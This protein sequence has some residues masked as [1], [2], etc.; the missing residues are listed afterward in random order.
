MNVLANISND[1]ERASSLSPAPDQVARVFLGI[2]DGDRLHFEIRTFDDQKQRKDK[3]LTRTLK[4]PRGDLRQD[5]ALWEELTALNERGAGVF[6]TVNR[7]DGKGLSAENVTGVTALFADTDGAELAPLLRLKPHIVVES[8]P[9]NWHVYWKVGDCPLD[10]FTALQQAIIA[11][12]GTDKSVHDLPRVMRLPGFYH[13]KREPFL[14]T[15]RLE[16]MD[17]CREPYTPQQVIDG[18]GLTVGERDDKQGSL[19]APQGLDGLGDNTKRPPLPETPEEIAKVRSMLNK[20]PPD[21]GR[22]EWRDVV[23]GV[24]ATGW[25]CAEELAREWSQRSSKWDEG[26]FAGVVK[27][28]RKDGGIGFG[29]LVHI[30]R[31]YGWTPTR[32]EC[33]T[34]Q[35]GSASG[36]LAERLTGD[37]GDVRNG[38]IFAQ[39]FRDKLLFVHETNDLLKFDTEAGWLAAPPHEA[40]R[41][42]KEALAEMRAYAADRWKAAPDDNNT[43]RLMTHVDRSSHAQRLYAMIGL[44]KSEPGMTVSLNEFDDDPWLLGVQ[45]GVIDLR[46]GRLLPV[47][48][49]VRVSKRCNAM[50]DPDADCPRFKQFLAEI[51]PDEEVRVYLQRLAGYCLTGLVDEQVFVFLYGLGRNGKSVL[52]ETMAW[53]MGDYA[54]KV[55]TEML[56]Q[57]QRDPQGP[58]P[59]IVALKGRRFIYATETEDGARLAAARVKE[60]TGGDTLTG[61][62]PYGKD[63]ITFRPTHKLII[64]GNHKPEIGDNSFGMWRRVLLTPFETTI[65]TDKCDPQLLAKLKEEGPGILNWALA[66]L[67]DWR[68]GGLS[69]P[70]HIRAATDAYRD[71]NDII[72]EWIRENCVTGTGQAARKDQLYSNYETWAKA[73]GFKP[74]T[75]KRLTRKLGERGFR[76]ANDHRTIDGISIKQEQFGQ[77]GGI[78][79]S[80]L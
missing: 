26:D 79:P 4:G 51:Q 32:T 5:S 44:A 48:P 64:V 6:V 45:N 21:T 67:R 42:A 75:Q 59:D 52:V 62:V 22:Y 2:L 65:S 40:E 39:L 76:V 12:F 37:S 19:A 43:K 71:E 54:H 18:L 16:D 50:F 55:P 20:I 13:N 53:L 63:F 34:T 46:T 31:E 66:G 38:K 60:M 11:K 77:A 35:E 8:S 7:T 14:T 41:A 49:K 25:R 70:K 33:G 68:K 15:L 36:L 72:G 17:P 10:Q 57:H 56:M 78:R 47:S 27:S 74:M 3:R 30:A 29:T 69:V 23:W 9:G 61:R 80:L 73:N 1:E 24:Q 58:S 28:F